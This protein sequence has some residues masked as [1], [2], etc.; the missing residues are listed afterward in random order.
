MRLCKIDGLL[1]I[2]QINSVALSREHPHVHCHMMVIKK[3][4]Y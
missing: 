4:G 1:Q 3:D 2:W